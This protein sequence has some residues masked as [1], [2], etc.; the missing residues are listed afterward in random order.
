T[1]ALDERQRRRL[2]ARGIKALPAA[3]AVAA[4]AR[5]LTSDAAQL[6]VLA[7]D[8]DPPADAVPP[9]LSALFT[10]AA[11]EAVPEAPARHRLADRLPEL[12]PAERQAETLDFLR[13]AI[14]AV[15]DL[16]ADEI[17]PR[18]SVVELG[19]DSLLVMEVLDR[20]RDALGLT[21]YPREFYQLPSITAMADY[22]LVAAQR[23]PAP[24]VEHAQIEDAER[25]HQDNPVDRLTM[26]LDATLAPPAPL[27]HLAFIQS[28]PREGS[29]LLRVMFAGHPQAFS[30]PELW[31]ALA[32]SMAQRRDLLGPTGLTEGLPIAV[33][34][35]LGCTT[36]E[37][38]AQVAAMEAEDLPVP[39]AYARLVDWA[40]GRLVLDKTPVYSLRPQV[41]ER[42]HGWM[43]RPRH[44]HLVR[45]PWAMLKS[46]DRARLDRLMLDSRYSATTIAEG[47]WHLSHRNLLDLAERSPGTVAVVRFEDLVTQPRAEMER[48]CDFLGLPF[49]EAA[50]HPYS[51]D[52]MT[53]GLHQTS[54]SIGDINF[55][56]HQAI[57]PALADAWRGAA[58]ERPMLPE[59]RALAAHF[60]YELPGSTLISVPTGAPARTGSARL[61][62]LTLPVL[63]WGP[64]NAPAVLAVH[65]LLDHAGYFAP[66]AEALAAH[67][68]RTIAFDLRGHGAADHLGPEATYRL[69][70]YV[71]DL[72]AVLATVRGPIAALVG[73]SMGAAIV[74][75]HSAARPGAAEARVLVEPPW[76]RAADLAEW[77]ERLGAW[78]DARREAP[79]HPPLADL[80]AA[81]IRLRTTLGA[82]PDHVL[83]ALARRVTRPEGDHLVWRWDARLRDRA[84]QA[85]DGVDP[86]HWRTVLAGLPAPTRLVFAEESRFVRPDDR[87]AQAAARP[88]ETVVLP[89]GH[90]LPVE[91]PAALAE[92]IRAAIRPASR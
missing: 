38:V 53:G 71:R 35:L 28:A 81:I 43:A 3:R 25:P 22:V 65:G 82:A 92:V 56:N 70:D 46:F 47:T 40:G 24:A 58:P 88:E 6:T 77:P 23:T 57:D 69:A 83:A 89:G 55:A 63:E 62:Q 32:N 17:D 68:L 76:P 91:Q 13:G 30:P 42:L 79:T 51:G 49:D 20:I 8:G 39:T 21:L 73:H 10:P 41:L 19:M 9:L 27:P 2:G 7:H 1:A 86:A 64:T 34:A 37:A 72:D 31:L 11:A 50:L 74:G 78:L 67:G 48:L 85:L 52:R 26:A 14:A 18:Q 16:A 80:D 36:E 15:L 12:T 29:T 54:A 90:A 87:A 44:I 59:T 5:A 60:G 66:L 84:E 33:R 45:H 75:L 4:F 61:G